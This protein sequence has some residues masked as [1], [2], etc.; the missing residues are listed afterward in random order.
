MHK[1]K[2]Y[3]YNNIPVGAVENVIGQNPGCN[4][5]TGSSTLVL[6]HNSRFNI[7]QYDKAI[8]KRQVVDQ[9]LI[10]CFQLVNSICIRM[11]KAG[12]CS[13]L[14]T[15][16]Q[17]RVSHDEVQFERPGLLGLVRAVWALQ[18]SLLAT[19]SLVIAEARLVPIRAA[20]V[21]ARKHS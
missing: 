1:T 5:S 10:H 11:R 13:R 15:S 19:L 21:G 7:S 14:S 8:Y 16:W 18:G 17:V 3:K 4:D 9:Q 12:W 2:M 20:A 6:Y